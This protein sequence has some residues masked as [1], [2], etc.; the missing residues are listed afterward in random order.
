VIIDIIKAYL[1]NR[2]ITI[3]FSFDSEIDFIFIDDLVNAHVLA[4]DL[5]N[6]VFNLSYGTST[7]ISEIKNII[8]FCFNNKI[9]ILEGSNSVQLRI[10][11]EKLKSKGWK[12][13]TDIK[14]GI[15]K[16]INYFKQNLC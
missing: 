6:E 3:G 5:K 7:K 9:N 14:T 1:E 8:S 10:G 11:C 16:T 2:D 4:L 15:Q 13:L 12:P